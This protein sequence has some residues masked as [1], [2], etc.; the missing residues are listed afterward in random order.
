MHLLAIFIVVALTLHINYNENDR[1][2]KNNF[3]AFVEYYAPWCVHCNALA[4]EYTKVATL[5]EHEKLE[6]K[7]GKV[8]A[9]EEGDLAGKYG[10]SKH[11][12]LKNFSSGSDIDYTGRRQADDMITWLKKKTGSSAKEL[13]SVEEAKAFVEES[14]VVVI[15]LFKDRK[16][17]EAKAFSSTANSV[18]NYPF[19]VTSNEEVYKNYET[20]CDSDNLFK[21]FDKKEVVF[22]GEA[23]SEEALK[24]FVQSQS[25]PLLIEFNHETA[26]KILGEDNKNHLLLFLSKKG[27]YFNSFIERARKVAK[28]FRDQVLFVTINV[29]IEDHQR[30]LKYFGMKKEDVP[31]MR[32]LELDMAEYKPAAPYHSTE[33]IKEF[34]ESFI[35]GKLKQHLTSQDLPEDCYK[36]P[37]KVLDSSNFDELAFNSGKDILVPFY[38]PWC[39]HCKQLAPIYN[40]LSKKYKDSKSVVT[41]KMDA[42]VNKMK[43]TKTTSFPTPKLCSKGKNKVID[44]NGKRTLNGFVQFLESSGLYG[45]GPSDEAPKI[46]K[47]DYVSLKNEL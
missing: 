34:V 45:K 22:E 19:G 6:T 46:D 20:K 40:E 9:A 33:N 47:S 31:A 29:D 43:H 2:C 27:T 5:L 10:V 44:F 4:L 28:E 1:T 15:D 18:E 21:K 39:R 17:A 41:A 25:L 7:V 35:E 24:K 36:S 38:A 3:L 14:Q 23:T 13:E 8:D 37:V 16:S 11:S 30:I 32:I 42:T 26:Q 12:A